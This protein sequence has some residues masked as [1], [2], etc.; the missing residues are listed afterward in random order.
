[1]AIP[2]EYQQAR[3]KAYDRMLKALGDPDSFESNPDQSETRLL[4]NR[5]ERERERFLKRHDLKGLIL[6]DIHLNG[7]GFPL[8]CVLREGVERPPYQEEI[9][10][11]HPNRGPVVV[12]LDHRTSIE[13]VDRLTY[14]YC[15][16]YEI[17][18]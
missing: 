15:E 12:T 9:I 10:A 4:R 14:H 16:V 2:I 7:N 3:L 8:G 18:Y 11:M 1:M 6:A 17:T 13:G 5:I